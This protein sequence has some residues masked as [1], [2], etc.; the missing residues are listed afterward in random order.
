MSY[1]NLKDRRV[2][3]YLEDAADRDKLRQMAADRHTSMSK[4][5]ADLLSRSI[6]EAWG[7][8]G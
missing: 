8:R 7:K 6:R 2:T 5:A 3:A 4:V 1:D